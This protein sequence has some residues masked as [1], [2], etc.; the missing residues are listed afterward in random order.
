MTLTVSE[1]QAGSS[2]RVRGKP[3]VPMA[4]LVFVL[5]HPRACGE[6]LLQ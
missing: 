6:N 1:T 2:P 5:A 3:I 4:V